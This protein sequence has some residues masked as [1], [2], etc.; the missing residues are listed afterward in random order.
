M[1]ILI[2]TNVALDILLNRQP[3]YTHAALIFGLT[4][5]KYIKSFISAST[6]TDIFY[7]SQK[8]HGK[9]AAREAIKSLLQVFSPAT[10]TDSNIFQA[11][12]LE[13]NDFEDSLQYVVGKTLLA[14]FI[15]TR[16]TQDFTSGSIPA[17]TPEQF[18][19]TVT[20]IEK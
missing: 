6:V 4:Q 9:K 20:V 5:Q 14:D 11:L 16:N 3:W 2:D 8:E 19:Q 15:V 7:I 17:V 13:W 10:V 18:I 12:N 1:T